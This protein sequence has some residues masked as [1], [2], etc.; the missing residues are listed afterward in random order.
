MRYLVC[1]GYLDGECTCK[2]RLPRKL[3]E[4]L[5]SRVISDRIL[6]SSIWL[7]ATLEQASLS[8]DKRQRENPAEEATLE[9]AIQD[10]DRRI[11][12]LVDQIE[13]GKADPEVSKRLEE[14]R[15]ERA[16]TQRRLSTLREAHQQAPQP[17]TT[18]WLVSKL[19]SLDAVLASGEGAAAI[20]LGKL[21]GTIVVE[22]IPRPGRKRKALRGTFTLTT[23]SVVGMVNEKDECG[24]EPPVREETIV[25]DFIEPL[26]W[27]AVV[28]QVKRLLD[29]GLNDREI[30]E[31]LNIPK[32]WVPKALAI[33]CDIHGTLIGNLRQHPKPRLKP[34]KAM[35][36]A[37]RAKELWDTGMPMQ[38][39][40]AQLTADLGF[41]FIVTT[42]HEQ[43]AIGTAAVAYRRPMEETGASNFGNYV[44]LRI[45]KSRRDDL[46]SN[47]VAGC[48][49]KAAVNHF[50]RFRFVCLAT[51]SGIPFEP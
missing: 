12:R 31:E 30:A 19:Q 51:P 4:H 33:W 29:K 22:E 34:T 38:K 45:R 1:A 43:S 7:Q 8:W 36:I 9:E 18:E 46:Q 35:R 37:D 13:T 49:P 10:F 5:I 3:A 42:S 21:I 14:R 40:A 24:K 15:A 44:I 41:A 27:E 11:S 50:F 26:P 25:I 23:A 47:K 39:I 28:D 16:A 20:A 32:S 17:P 48:R 6:G 2:T